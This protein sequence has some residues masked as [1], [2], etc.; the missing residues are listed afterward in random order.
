MSQEVNISLSAEQ[1]L[2]GGFQPNLSNVFASPT[3]YKH[4]TFQRC[5]LSVS[6]SRCCVVLKFTCCLD[7]KAVMAV[8]A[9]QVISAEALKGRACVVFCLSC[10]KNIIK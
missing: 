10:Y 2:A 1:P 8:M 5:N 4:T 9:Q 6:M 7:N 3:L